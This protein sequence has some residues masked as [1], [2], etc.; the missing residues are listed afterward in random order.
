MSSLRANSLFLDQESEE[1]SVMLFEIS[2]RNARPRSGL[3]IERIALENVY[4]G[5]LFQEEMREEVDLT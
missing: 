3:R 1:V 4:T 2:F 5:A